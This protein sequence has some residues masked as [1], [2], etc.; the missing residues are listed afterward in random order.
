VNASY[1]AVA[2]AQSGQTNLTLRDILTDHDTGFHLAMAPAFF[3]FYGYFGALAAWY[4][5]EP[6]LPVR[7][8][9]GASAGAMAAILMGAGISPQVAADFCAEMTLSHFADFPGFGAVFRGHKF[10]RLMDEFLTAATNRTSLSGSWQLQEAILPVAVTAFD[11]QT[12]QGKILTTGSMARAA[13]AS[14]TFPLLF[15]PVG[16]LDSDSS[17]SS[18]IDDQN[19]YIFID[20]GIADPNGLV[21]LTKTLPSSS[22]RRV[23]NLSIGPFV[24]VRPPFDITTTELIS[25]SI[26]GLPQPGPLAMDKGPKSFTAAREAMRKALDTTLIRRGDVFELTIVYAA[27]R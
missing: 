18:N 15:Q 7:S 14:A 5:L 13:R 10:E 2:I 12:F 4:D 19:D 25:I 26:E 6:N 3:G 23:V 21:G 9:A 8:L 20:G 24:P 17:P 27:A 22:C 16:W 1:A 11:L